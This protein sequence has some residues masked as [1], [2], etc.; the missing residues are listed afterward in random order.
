LGYVTLF[1]DTQRCGYAELKNRIKDIPISIG[2]LQRNVQLI[3]D[4]LEEWALNKIVVGDE[5]AWERSMKNFKRGKY[6]KYVN[7]FIDSTNYRLRGKNS[8]STSHPSW[9]FKKN[10]PA[11]RY[12]CIFDGK[13]RIIHISRGHSPKIY[14]GEHLKITRIL[15]KVSSMV[16][17]Y[18]ETLILKLERNYSKI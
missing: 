3:R 6:V 15:W 18:V 4:E 2:T 11:K 9:S 10:E 14:D 8:T 12:M 1:K 13:S 5:F 17:V 16:D 7:L